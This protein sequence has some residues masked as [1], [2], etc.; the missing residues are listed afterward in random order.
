MFLSIM[1]EKNEKKEVQER[2]QKKHE[3]SMDFGCENGRFREAKS[4]KNLCFYK[5][6]HDFHRFEK[7]EKWSQNGC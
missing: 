4:L 2:C 6:F 5:V 1:L 7:D 3:I